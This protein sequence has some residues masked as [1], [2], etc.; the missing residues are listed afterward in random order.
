MKRLTNILKRTWPIIAVA[1]LSLVLVASVQHCQEEEPTAA[2]TEKPLAAAPRF[3]D[4]INPPPQ[5]DQGGPLPSFTV[6]DFQETRS[7]DTWTI[8]GTVQQTAPVVPGLNFD[9]LVIV[10]K[11]TDG[12]D[13][14]WRTADH[15]TLRGLEGPVSF[16]LGL[17]AA[18]YEDSGFGFADFADF[19]DNA[20]VSAVVVQADRARYY[21]KSGGKYIA[22]FVV[23][24]NERGTQ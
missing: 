7:A 15:D 19:Q 18:T 21:V 8:S 1:V 13:C 3:P 11:Y 16:V 6:T 22:R 10:F 24:V 2:V 4:L 12:R 20:Q 23:P 5:E 14:E 17:Q 9:R